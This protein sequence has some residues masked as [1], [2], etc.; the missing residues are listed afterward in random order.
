[1][2][3]NKIG[4]TDR[5]RYFAWGRGKHKILLTAGNCRKLTGE[6]FPENLGFWEAKAI[7]DD[8]V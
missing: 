1:M 2:N 8:L 3:T 4:G 7:A 6:T 5:N